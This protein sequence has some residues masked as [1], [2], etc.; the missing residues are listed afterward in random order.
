M[1]PRLGF[2]PL[3]SSF[4][5]TPITYRERFQC[6]SPQRP[7]GKQHA[8]HPR[9][10]LQGTRPRARVAAG[11]RLTGWEAPSWP[12]Q[13]EAIKIHCDRHALKHQPGSPGGP[14][15]GS[16]QEMPPQVLGEGRPGSHGRSG[17][18]T[19]RG[20]AGMCLRV[21]MVGPEERGLVVFPLRGLRERSEGGIRTSRTACRE[22]P[23]SSEKT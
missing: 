14:H 22:T 18:G 9:R 21:L 13:Q 12:G 15:R 8:D 7:V 4:L 23:R 1:F 10:G 17:R 20:T 19:G 16:G 6:V 2:S 3:V 11:T 5:R